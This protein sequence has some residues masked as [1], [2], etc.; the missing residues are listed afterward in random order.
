MRVVLD[1]L[2]G[3]G[4]IV[5]LAVVLLVAFVTRRSVVRRRGATL[6]CGLRMGTSVSSRGWHTGM[7]RYTAEDLEWF[8]LLSLRYQPKWTFVRR[9]IEI[10]SR[11]EPRGAETLAVPRDTV[12]IACDVITRQGDAL[13][14]EFA[15]S[16]AAVTGFLAWIE[17]SAP[18]AHSHPD[19]RV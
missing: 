7:A 6:H 15:M 8:R 10:N 19:T 16:E 3:A 5:V 13:G 11:R 14:V 18:G 17:S 12:I 2:D 9:S 4:W 1:F